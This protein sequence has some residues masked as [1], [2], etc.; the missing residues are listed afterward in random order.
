MK[1]ARIVILIAV[2]LIVFVGSAFASEM[3]GTVTAVNVEKATLTLKNQ[4]IEAGF[5]C[6]TGSIIKGVKVGDQVM[7]EYNEEGGKKK[8]TKVTPMK[9]KPQV[10]C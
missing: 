1:G 9:P 10:G 5:D 6:E 7:V 2:V 8:A 3:S 4:T